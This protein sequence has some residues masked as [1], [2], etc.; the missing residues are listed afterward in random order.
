MKYKD[1]LTTSMT[2]LGQVD[3][4]I[5]LGQSIV[6]P[7]HAMFHTLRGVPLEK[8]I[9]M[10]VA[11]ELQM[12]ISAG[13]ALEGY[14]PISI[15]P[16]M[17]FLMCCM[18][19]LVNHL[20]KIEQM[21]CGQYRPKVIIRTSIGSVSPLN[22]GPQHCQDHIGTLR[23]ALKNIPVWACKSSQGVLLNYEVAMKYE[24]SVVLV[25]YT[26]LYEEES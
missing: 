8:K 22:P 26:D 19:Q 17:D 11:E 18:N 2:L 3:N 16:R 4:T 13:L 5:F 24:G 15:F 14:L 7:G 12:G 25:E 10:P 21:S 1:A 6:Y 9:E 20:D 23:K